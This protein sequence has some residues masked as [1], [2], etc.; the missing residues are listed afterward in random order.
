MILADNQRKSYTQNVC[1][2]VVNTIF[3]KRL[4]YVTDSETGVLSGS[5]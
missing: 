1:R 5:K 3:Y 2:I 4:I